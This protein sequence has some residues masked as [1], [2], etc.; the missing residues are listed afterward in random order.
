MTPMI[1]DDIKLIKKLNVIFGKLE[2]TG[3]DVYFLEV[4]N[5]MKTLNNVLKIKDMQEIFLELVNLN[6]QQVVLYMIHNVDKI[7]AQTLRSFVEEPEDED[8]E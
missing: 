6:Y 2:K 1:D 7:N 5:I 4:I 8:G 3:K